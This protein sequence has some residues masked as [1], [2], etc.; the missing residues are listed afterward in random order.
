[1]VLYMQAKKENISQFI[2]IHPQ[3]KK[4]HNSDVDLDMCS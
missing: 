3:K 1:M 2:K 4:Y